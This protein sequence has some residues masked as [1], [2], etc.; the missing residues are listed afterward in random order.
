MNR[1]DFLHSLF[2][3][4]A[5]TVLL[6]NIDVAYAASG[7]RKLRKIGLQLYTVR[8][9]LERDFEATLRRIAD[10]GIKEV[11][12][13]GYF[14]RSPEQIYKL[15]KT[16]RLVSPSAHITTETLRKSLPDAIKTAK[17]IGHKYLVLGYLPEEERRSLNDYRKLIRLLNPTGEECR[18]AGLQFAYHNH[19]FEFAEIDGKTPYDLI[20]AETD[21]QAVKM[22]LDLYWITKAGLSPISYFERHPGRFPLVH[23][24]DMDNTAR[25]FFTEV[26]RGVIDFR[27]IFSHAKTAGI[28]H[29]FI[30]QDETPGEPIESVK[31]SLK[32][33][34]ALKF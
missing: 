31:I 7:N 2:Y 3:G 13:A 27:K 21:A 12:F 20:L 24:K 10:L 33:L 9:D 26:G 6:N 18:K 16:L 8:R 25:K 1:R 32:N 11:E 15:L 14:G 29:Y 34:Q 17:I 23:V 22:E 30:E 5:G 19:D 28:E 4:L